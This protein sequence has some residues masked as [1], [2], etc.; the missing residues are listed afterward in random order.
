MTT[1]NKGIVAGF[2]SA[3]IIGLVGGWGVSSL[4][5]IRWQFIVSLVV[6]LFILEFALLQLE[7]E[8]A[9]KRF[10]VKIFFL[11]LGMFSFIGFRI[12]VGHLFNM[13]LDGSYDAINGVGTVGALH[14]SIP[15]QLALEILLVL[16]AGAFS[17]LLVY[18]GIKTKGF[19]IFCSIP[20]FFVVLWQIKQPENTEALNRNLRGTVDLHT[21]NL[22]IDALKKEGAAASS[23]GIAR[24]SVN[25]FYSWDN[26]T[27]SVSIMENVNII[28]PE[29][30]IVMQANPG[31]KGVSY[32]GQY[33]IQVILANNDGSF[34]GGQKTWVESNSFDW[35]DAGKIIPNKLSIVESIDGKTKTWKVRFLTDDFVRID[36][37]PLTPGKG[38]IITGAPEGELISPSTKDANKFF[39]V[40]QGIEIT[41][42]TAG[43][44]IIRYK[45]GGEINIK[46]L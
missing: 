6:F 12:V 5:P 27:N 44:L 37:I 29:G 2:L 17:Y 13:P 43:C 1:I 19:I 35:V 11:I 45:N 26:I 16:P 41:D 9:T 28:I 18:G 40:P 21:S 22:N 23:Y 33:F 42:L 24:I 39:N 30:G 7:K 3:L 38:I 36:S 10:A 20:L 31:K 14:K 32:E 15:A 8:S 34:F 25:K 4:M 46:I